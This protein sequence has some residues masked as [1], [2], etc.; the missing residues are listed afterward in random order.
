VVLGSA[1]FRIAAGHS[2]VVKVRVARR[3]LKGVRKSVRIVISAVS[4]TAT[5]QR[6][7][8]QRKSTLYVQRK[9]RLVG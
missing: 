2:A 3:T 4:R 6:V 8:Y 5:G 7:S 9:A 1:Q